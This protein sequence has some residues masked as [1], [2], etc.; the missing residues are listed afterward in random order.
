VEL[1]WATLD[2]MPA[3]WSALTH[4]VF[5]TRTPLRLAFDGAERGRRL[6]YAM[7]WENTRGDKGP[8]S[9]IAETVIP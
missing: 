6:F 1:V 8:W 7:R 2:A 3:D 4:S 9:E 5:D